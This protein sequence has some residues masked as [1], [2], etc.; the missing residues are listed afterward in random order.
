MGW[1]GWGSGSRFLPSLLSKNSG[2]DR[3]YMLLYS[4]FCGLYDVI[5]VLILLVWYDVGKE[6]R[7]RLV[8]W[9]EKALF[10]R[11]NK[12]FVITSNKRNHQ[13][14]LSDRNLLAV[15]REPQ[16]YILPIIPWP[17]PKVLV[18]GEH[19]VL[20]D[21]PFYEKVCEVNAKACQDCLEQKEKKR[22]EGKKPPGRY[23]HRSS[24]D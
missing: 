15:V 17:L 2:W 13:T 9:V 11:L 18:P 19:Y 14:L 12:L 10:D 21:L 7:D 24:P 20:K 8:E 3:L 23:F 4:L 1:F 22:Q 5:L 6:R 16:L